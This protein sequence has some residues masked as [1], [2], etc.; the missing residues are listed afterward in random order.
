MEGDVVPGGAVALGEDPLMPGP[1]LLN[2]HSA[3]DE[4]HR[5]PLG[6]SESEIAPAEGGANQGS[7]EGRAEEK[8][9][10]LIIID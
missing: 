5:P 6:R 8:S 1:P 10:V 2:G 9:E 3:L 7:D 4:P